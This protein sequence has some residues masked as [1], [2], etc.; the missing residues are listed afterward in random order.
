V[1]ATCL[2]IIIQQGDVDAFASV[3]DGK[4]GGDGGFPTSTFAIDYK[5]TAQW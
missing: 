4:I 3:G 5:N 1:C 2:W